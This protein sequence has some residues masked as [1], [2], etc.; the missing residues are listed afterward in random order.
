VCAPKAP[1]GFGV[2]LC[3]HRDGDVSCPEVDYTKKTLVYRS[4]ADTRGCSACQCDPP[5]GGTCPATVQTY[6]F[7][8]TCSGGGSQILPA[9]GSCASTFKNVSSAVIHTTGAPTGASCTHTGG[10]PTG[11][12]AVAQPVTVCCEP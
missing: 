9:D 5:T 6:P 10:A 4:I 8:D 2:P 3:I 1:E 11:A 7:Q 12:A